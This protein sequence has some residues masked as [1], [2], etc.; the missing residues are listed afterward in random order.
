MSEEDRVHLF[1]LLMMGSVALVAILG[2]VAPRVL[3][4]DMGEAASVLRFMVYGSI[5]ALVALGAY[6]RALTARLEEARGSANA[7]ILSLAVAEGFAVA[8]IVFAALIGETVWVLAVAAFAILVL[9]RIRSP[10]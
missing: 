2:T 8:G 4:L 7:R 6:G 10:G 5:A 9:A 3:D 1:G